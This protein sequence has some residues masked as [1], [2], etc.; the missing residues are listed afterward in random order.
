MSQNR[1]DQC[2][3]VFSYMC[4]T[5]GVKGGGEESFDIFVHEFTMKFRT[6]GVVDEVLL[7]FG[8]TNG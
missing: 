2:G 8:I 7:L 3:N 1:A 5:V 6:D 4:E